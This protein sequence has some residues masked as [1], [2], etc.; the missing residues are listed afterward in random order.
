MKNFNRGGKLSRG[1]GFNTR[2][3]GGRDND[4]Q[5]YQA[6]CAECGKECEVP[7]KPSGDKPVYCSSCFENKRG[8]KE[9]YR[10]PSFEEK[11]M[12]AATCDICGKACEVPFKPTAGKPV[13]CNDCFEKKG[14]KKNRGGGGE[15][16]SKQ[17]DILNSKLDQILKVLVPA[18]EKKSAPKEAAPK[19]VKKIEKSAKGKSAA[20]GKT[21]KKPS[22]KKTSAKKAKK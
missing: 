10:R 15:Q 4:R 11:R 13:Y 2:G 9:D 7:F 18:S 22:V 14:G 19:A 3:F 1:G 5:M 12:F 6:T 17:F 8:R 16:S 21:A 20:N